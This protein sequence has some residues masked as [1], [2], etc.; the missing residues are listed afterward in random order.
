MTK[1]K[2][3]CHRHTRQMRRSWQSEKRMPTDCDEQDAANKNRS[4]T[5]F[6]RHCPQNGINKMLKRA[7]IITD[8]STSLFVVEVCFALKAKMTV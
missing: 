7:I 5:D 2:Y 3:H 4:S 6:V 1:A 8:S